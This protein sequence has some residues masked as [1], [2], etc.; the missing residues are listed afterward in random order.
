MA[1]TRRSLL[2]GSLGVA[3][4]ALAGCSSSRE[5]SAPSS[6]ASASATKQAEVPFT[7]GNAAAAPTLDP[8]I[9]SSLET[10]RISAQVLETLVAADPDTGKPTPGLATKWTS[11]K[12]GLT[13]TFTLRR[14]V[15]FHDGTKLTADVVRKNFD[16]WAKNTDTEQVNQTAYQTIF[17][18]T[19]ADGKAQQTIYRSCTALDDHTVELKISTPYPSIVKALTQPAFGIGSPQA[20]ADHEKF[21]SHPVGTGPFRMESWDGHTAKLSRF[22]DYWGTSAH[23][24]QLTFLTVPS[25]QKRYYEL[26][27]QSVDAYDQVGIDDFVN[28][29]RRGY[30]I[31]QRDPYSVAF[32]TMNQ[33]AGPL[34]DVNVRRAAAHALGRSQI[35]STQYPN[36][37][38]VANDFVPELFKMGGEDTSSAYR[39]D[40]GLSKRLLAESGYKGEE[41]Q[42]YYPTN[43]SLAYI[44]QPEA[45]FAKIAGDLT[46]VGFTIKPMPIRWDDDY[47]SKIN[48][49]NSDRAFALTGYMGA[50]RDPDDFISPLFRQDNPQFGFTDQQLFDH[51]HRAA[52]LPDG[53]E[54]SDLY[55]KVNEDI[56]EIMP[57]IPIAYPVSAVALSP[58]VISYPLAATGVE[59]LSLV[60]LRKDS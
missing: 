2:T 21:G 49:A 19:A 13:Y 9:T 31:Q 57:A 51:V 6:G 5:S 50:Y 3:G 25:S 41:L 53:D 45:V 38:N 8:S 52:G 22:P 46:S 18:S 27:A 43:V 30:Q 35:A 28:L 16:R 40:Q 55:K 17:R 39:Q 10:S 32:V 54:R 7:F 15:T 33:K 48:S 12:D 59:N 1:P 60:E 26:L 34:A 36:G 37:T 47:L 58:K 42:F 23:I 20:F 14:N 4:I 44:Q 56:A 11:S 29:A 24:T